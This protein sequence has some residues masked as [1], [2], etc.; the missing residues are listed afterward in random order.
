MDAQIILADAAQASPDG[1]V[2][3]LGLGWSTTTTPLPPQALV[4]L[5]KC[6]WD[7]T[8]DAHRVLVEL[9]DSDGRPV[10]LPGPPD[11]AMHP[12][13]IEAQF[14]TGR[15]PGLRPGT[16]IDVP[17]A[18]TVGGGMPLPAGRYTWELSIDEEKQESWRAAF[19][20]RAH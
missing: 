3:A 20:V 17:L 13:R 10:E 1:K 18:F 8:D 14:E 12:L 16:P 4:L 19:D 11:G 9:V 2:H 6:P 15:P 5:I 7:Q